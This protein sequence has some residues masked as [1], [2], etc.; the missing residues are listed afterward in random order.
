MALGLPE[1]GNLDEKTSHRTRTTVGRLRPSF[2]DPE[3]R[4]KKF[5]ALLGLFLGGLAPAQESA[6]YRLKPYTLNVGGVPF[7]L[8]TLHIS[9]SYRVRP[10]ALGEAMAGA[11]L[12]STSFALAA[13]IGLLCRPAGEVT[14]LSFLSD[15]VT[16]TWDLDPTME[17]YHL[18]RDVVPNFAPSFGACQQF[19]IVG[20]SATDTATP[21]V[22]QAYYYLVTA[23]DCLG[24][25]GPKGEGRG[26]LF[27]CP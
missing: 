2:T 12:T 9:T 7:D 6:S 24:Q 14:N 18:Y 17:H 5:F 19:N 1:M 23:V 3:D 13:G 10:S 4:M 21:G 25:E 8:T 11:G 27:E 20:P 15:G 22:T 16:L 26:N